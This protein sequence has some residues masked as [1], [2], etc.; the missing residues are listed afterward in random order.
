MGCF[1]VA[2][3]A[4]G[5]TIG[6]GD[7]VVLFPLIPTNFQYNKKISEGVLIPH[8]SNLVSNDGACILYEPFCLPI[9]GCYNDYGGIENIIE[10]ENTKYL[11]NYFGLDIQTIAGSINGD[12]SECSNP[13][14]NIILA[15]LAGMWECRKFYDN[16]V[17]EFN[18]TNSSYECSD[19]SKLNLDLLGFVKNSEKNTGDDRYNIYM[20]HP[21]IKELIGHSDGTWTNFFYKD[22]PLNQVY[23]IKELV[24]EL[25]KLNIDT[26]LLSNLKKFKNTSNCLLSIEKTIQK[27]KSLEKKST[28][29]NESAFMIEDVKKFF[30][31]QGKSEEEIK[32]ILNSLTITTSFN[33][34]RGT[35]MEYNK[36]LQYAV[37]EDLKFDLEKLFSFKSIL[38]S[39]NKIFMPCQ[40]GEQH[41]NDK[42]H[43]M[44][45][46]ETLKILDYKLGFGDF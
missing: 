45:T 22:K 39:V 12:L 3:T 9:K 26:Y 43:R 35:I 15:S 28:S 17:K 8:S 14:K 6:C 41:G 2:S 13:D 11:E 23:R 10:D 40:S 32:K 25:E 5:L 29:T 30:E 31:K 18:K 46:K 4:S 19:L 21:N 34:Y 33:P 38:C 37:T 24:Q 42:L 1:N 20:T 27:I 16:L 36:Y 44:F 7:E